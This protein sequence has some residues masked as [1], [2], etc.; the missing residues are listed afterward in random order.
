M[1]EKISI[2]IPAFN[3]ETAIAG[4]LRDI[5][6]NLRGSHYG[7]E[8]IVIDDASKDQ[9]AKIAQQEG[10]KV[11]THRQNRGYGASIKTGLR[12]SSG[13]FIA[14]IDADG[15]YQGKDLLNLAGQI[16]DNDM[17]IGARTKPGVK[18]SA[19]RKIAKFFLNRLASYLVETKIPDLN[20]GLRIMKKEALNEF[21]RILPDS[22]S[23]TTTLTLAFLNCNLRISF[24]PIDY[25]K[26]HGKS[27]IRPIRDTLNFIQ[28]IIR[29]VMYF[30]PL[31]VFVPVSI[32][33]FFSG[34]A[35]LLYSKFFMPAVMDVTTVVLMLA[36]MQI[37]AIGMV[38]DLVIKKMG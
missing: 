34:V 20:S 16:Q 35:V 10:V 11:I 32:F 15:S 29:T 14:I 22:F 30:N 23:F 1:N 28:L 9:T 26:R 33:L 17:V 8:I 27:K 3:E 19:L 7:Y 18:K 21:L 38:A 4:V 25:K 37:L 31:K 5:K 36:S 13:Q 6:E 12:S 2:I 24:V